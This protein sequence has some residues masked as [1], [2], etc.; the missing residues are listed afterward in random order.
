MLVKSTPLSALIT[1]YWSA[2]HLHSI[3]NTCIWPC[4]V[5]PAGRSRELLTT[6]PPRERLESL[7]DQLRD[8][9]RRLVMHGPASST[10]SLVND[11]SPSLSPMPESSKLP[12]PAASATAPVPTPL[13]SKPTVGDHPWTH[14][15]R[16]LQ[17]LA[18]SSNGLG[19]LKSSMEDL[20]R[21]IA[22][23]EVGLFEKPS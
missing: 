3:S 11:P 16:F 9:T 23:H 15:R 20:A 14:L 8:K 7:K 12:T 21:C 4:L 10:N 6:M 17:V 2:V 22:L 18:K 19:L 1:R 5:N 13:S